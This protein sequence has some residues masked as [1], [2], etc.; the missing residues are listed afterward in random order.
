MRKLLGVLA[1][2]LGMVASQACEPDIK[3][4]PPPIINYIHRLI[5]WSSIPDPT[6]T[7]A[8]KD[9]PHSCAVI[10]EP[11]DLG[12]RAPYSTVD[13]VWNANGWAFMTACVIPARALGYSLPIQ[14]ITGD[15]Q[16]EEPTFTF[17]IDNAPIFG[18]GA[19]HYGELQ[20]SNISVWR[21]AHIDVV[22]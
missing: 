12:G 4:P 11:A 14:K 10:V 22:G 13:N 20:A 1:L 7:H 2:S 16:G 6:G 9:G 21:K 18:R 15:P 19:G 8:P 3:P 5:Y 17:Y